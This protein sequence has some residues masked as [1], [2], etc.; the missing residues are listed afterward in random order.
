[1]LTPQKAEKAPGA[2][3]RSHHY[4]KFTG[5]MNEIRTWLTDLRPYLRPWTPYEVRRGTEQPPGCPLTS[6]LLTSFSMALTRSAAVGTSVEACRAASREEDCKTLD[7][8]EK[9]D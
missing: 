9:A 3:F 5:G 7:S 1:M 6:L 8:K 2:F 4:T